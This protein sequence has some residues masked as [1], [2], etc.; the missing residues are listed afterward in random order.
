[1]AGKGP[2]SRDVAKRAGVS[3]A[4]VSFVLNNIADARISEATKE[5]VWQAVRE[6]DYHPNAAAQSLRRRAAGVIG[7][8]IPDSRNPHFW[9]I[10]QGAEKR[11]AEAGYNVLLTSTDL[12]FARE[13]LALES[14]KRQRVDALILQINFPGK[15]L[16]EV[17]GLRAR[18]HPIIRIGRFSP[19]LDG[20]VPDYGA[21][22]TRLMAHLVSLGHHRIGFVFGTTSRGSVQTEVELGRG[23]LEAYQRAIAE[24]SLDGDTELLQHCG[25]L[26]EEAYEATRRLLALQPLPTAI[27]S[28]N[29]FLA[30]AVCK[31]VADTGLRIPHD[32][33]VAGFDDIPMA[34]Y[35]SPALTTVRAEAERLG[36][37][38]V[39]MVLARLKDAS[40]PP[41]HVVLPT[42]LVV[43]TSTGVASVGTSME[44]N[45]AGSRLS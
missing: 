27:I 31:A 26:P 41:Q 44:A 25:P 8:V 7:F 9:Q 36:G 19:E 43:R 4:T 22:C 32:I 18:G 11:A 24:Y 17:E 40:L 10:A 38:A 16:P 21:G 30:I 34:R 6:L 12:E 1:M 15:L 28:I 23:R 33:S 35:L 13:R 5:K 42:S 29:D 45:L 37:M 39:E 2:T 3:Q 20:V 14:L